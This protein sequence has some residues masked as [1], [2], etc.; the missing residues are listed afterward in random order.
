MKKQ[1]RTI[2]GHVEVDQ[3]QRKLFEKI[4]QLA[5]FAK[6][7]IEVQWHKYLADQAMFDRKRQQVLEEYQSE[8][9]R[10]VFKIEQ[11]KALQQA[12]YE[13]EQKM[14]Q[15]QDLMVK[16]E[17]LKNQVQKPLRRTLEQ[18]LEDAQ[19]DISRPGEGMYVID[20]V[21]GVRKKIDKAI[22]A[23]AYEGD[24][25]YGKYNDDPL[26]LVDT[27]TLFKNS[28]NGLYLTYS[29]LY[30]KDMLSKRFV[31][32]LSDIRSIRFDRGDSKLSIN[33]NEVLFVPQDSLKG[34]MHALANA[35]KTYIE[36]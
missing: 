17:Q 1:L 30:C 34:S 14:S 2:E 33:G 18:I 7:D 27:T 8:L 13:H 32:R 12:K 23:Y 10:E 20:D 6:I 36:Q 21:Y 24:G 35:I 19:D 9:E 5:V 22:K 4:H 25:E 11:D 3:F 26:V 28:E 29:E 31:I 15:A 16:A